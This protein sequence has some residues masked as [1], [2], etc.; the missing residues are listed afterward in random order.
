[1]I[2][3]RNEIWRDVFDGFY[4]PLQKQIETQIWSDVKE[5]WAGQII[6]LQLRNQIDV[7]EELTRPF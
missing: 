5:G 3:I 1:M 6:W 4:L 2:E 7:S